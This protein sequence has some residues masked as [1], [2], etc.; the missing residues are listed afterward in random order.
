MFLFQ[1]CEYKEQM[2]KHQVLS[3]SSSEPSQPT[4]Q[5]TH[6]PDRTAEVNRSH[7]E[8]HT[9]DHGQTNIDT[10]ANNDAP[11]AEV[12]Q[13]KP[14]GRE[15]VIKDKALITHVE[16]DK[17]AQSLE[18][19]Q[20]N[21][22]KHTNMEPMQRDGKSIETFRWVMMHAAC[23]SDSCQCKERNHQVHNC[24]SFFIFVN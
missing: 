3:R 5:S 7:I 13:G 23:C 20:S 12:T 19:K 16:N 4:F 18:D 2:D 10:Q 24:T 17:K 8:E 9:Q 15:T 11:T 1:V 14:I 22:T 21:K 6:S